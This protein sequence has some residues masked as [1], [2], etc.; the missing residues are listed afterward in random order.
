MALIVFWTMLKLCHHLYKQS[1]ESLLY[2]LQMQRNGKEQTTI[3]P[4]PPIETFARFQ[5][6]AIIKK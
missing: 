6:P 2:Q 3:G 4:T 1:M 5:L